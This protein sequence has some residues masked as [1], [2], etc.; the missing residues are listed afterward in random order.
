M[1][2]VYAVD[3]NVLLRHIVGDERAL[4]EKARAVI[5]AAVAGE[6]ALACDPIQLGEAVWVLTS[7]Y[8][9]EP[10][11]IA[12]SLLPLLELPGME[13]PE[14][15]RYVRALELFGSGALSFGDACVCATAELEAEGRLISFDRAL[16]KV[17]GIE[18]T[19]V[20]GSR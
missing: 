18:R 11:E 14:K 7:R 20:V 6:V 5:A 2:V 3:A 16:S 15:E 19:E 9:V 8:K 13:M 10:A 1:P 17:P 4:Y 12:G